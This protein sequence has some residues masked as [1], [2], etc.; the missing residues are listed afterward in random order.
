MAIAL[1]HR[2]VSVKIYE[3]APQFGEVGAGVSFTPNALQAMRICH[4]G[5]Y[6]AFEKVCTRNLWPSKSKVWFDYY[7][8]TEGNKLDRPAFT[9]SNELGQNGVHRARFLDELVK[10]AP[11]GIAAFGKR[12]DR[13]EQ[14]ND[15]RYTLTF[16]DGA[17]A[18]ADAILA[19]DGIKSKVRQ[20]LFGEGHP[21]A[22]P[23]YTHKYAYRALVPMEEAVAAIG[24]EKAQNACM[25]VR[26]RRLDQRCPSTDTSCRWV[27]A[28]TC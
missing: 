27:M 12:L 11:H 5:V 24:E 20:L 21:C 1:H 14:N 25:H 4:P 19:C 6:E 15:G 22:L 26:K 8:G 13:F 7:D 9:I 17:T 18:E 3:Q 23:S 16:S 2:G 28:A 10:L